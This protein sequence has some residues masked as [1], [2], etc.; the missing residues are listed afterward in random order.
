ME[1]TRIDTYLVENGWAESRETARSLIMAGAVTLDGRVCDKPATPVKPGQVVAV[2]AADEFV[3]RG[4]KKLQKALTSFGID[5]NGAVAIDVGASTGGFTDCMLRAGAKLVYAVDVGYGQLAWRLRQDERV[6][7][8]ERVNARYLM[9]SMFEVPASFASIDVSFISLKLIL[10]ALMRVLAALHHRTLI[11]PQFEAVAS[12]WAKGV[13]R[14]K[15]VHRRRDS[16]HTRL[17]ERSRA[18]CLRVDFSPIRGPEGNIEYLACL[19]SEGEYP[20]PDIA[21]WWRRPIKRALY[22][23]AVRGLRKVHVTC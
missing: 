20:E 15:A 17:C 10:P 23:S 2:Q 21:A 22:V 7:V 1:K 14:D 3:S 8:M 12:A 4:G 19:K 11:K 5:L 16:G 9:P 6:R 18:F 13:V